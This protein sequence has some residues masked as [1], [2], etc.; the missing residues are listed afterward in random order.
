MIVVAGPPLDTPVPW[1]YPIGVWALLPWSGR[2]MTPHFSM[3]RPGAGG[4]S[5]TSPD[6]PCVRRRY[7]ALLGRHNLPHRVGCHITFAVVAHT[8]W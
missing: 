3:W 5:L 7:G 2:P 8:G 6:E 1:E 4:R